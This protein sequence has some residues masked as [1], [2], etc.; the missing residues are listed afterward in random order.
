M[1][2]VKDPKNQQNRKVAAQFPPAKIDPILPKLFQPH[3]F[4]C[5]DPFESIQMNNLQS[6]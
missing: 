2:R 5:L 3:T 6:S 1:S 4:C